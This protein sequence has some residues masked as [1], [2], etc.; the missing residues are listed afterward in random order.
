MRLAVLINTCDKFAD[1]WEPFC[2]LWA[3][4]GVPNSRLYLNTERADFSYEGLD[5]IPLRVC[6]THGWNANRP[7]AWG[8]CT[9]RALEAIDADII[10]Y[11]QEDYFLNTPA[12]AARIAELVQLMEREP[13]I[14]CIHLTECGI[15]RTEPCEYEGLLRGRKDDDCFAALQAALWR[16]STMQ[17]LLLEHESG[18]DWEYWAARRAKKR[19]CGF[20]VAAPQEGHYPMSYIFTGIIQG[21]WY[22]PVVELFAAHGINV[23]FSRRGF[24]EGPFGRKEGRVLAY[25]LCHLRACWK[26]FCM[27]YLHFRSIAAL[28]RAK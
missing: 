11:M 20:Y 15:T 21:K 14:D 24:Y 5:I 1:C 27:R 2:T 4:Y 7:P 10:L 25:H 8:W 19:N 22:R 6:T 9:A 18:W 23:D 17:A 28:R 12:D 13:S 16:K 3:Q 26:T